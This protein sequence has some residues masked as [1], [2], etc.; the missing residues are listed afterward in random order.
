MSIRSLM[1]I[2]KL[3]WGLTNLI[4][5]VI[6]ILI[7]I[8]LEVIINLLLLIL[9][10]LDY[11]LNIIFT[12]K[13]HFSHFYNFCNSLFTFSVITLPFIEILFILK[14]L[15]ILVVSCPFFSCLNNSWSSP[16]VLYNGGSSLLIHWHSLNLRFSMHRIPNTSSTGATSVRW[17]FFLIVVN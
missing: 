16:C 13:F 12:F 14:V 9:F 11:S 6:D 7:L 15:L 4:F 17:E 3:V 1:I 10:F 5:R 2:K 8:N